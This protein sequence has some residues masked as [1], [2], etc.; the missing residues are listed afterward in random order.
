MA[1]R[2]AHYEAYGVIRGSCGH[3]H[4]NPRG[5]VE[6]VELDRAENPGS[7]RFVYIVERGVRSRLWPEGEV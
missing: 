6:C 4:P 2:G 5:A 1:R 3:E 7:D